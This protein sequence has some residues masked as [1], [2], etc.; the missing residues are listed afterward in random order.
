MKN[1]LKSSFLVIGII[2]LSACATTKDTPQGKYFKGIVNHYFGEYNPDEKIWVDKPLNKYA[3]AKIKKSKLSLEDFEKIREKMKN[4]K[5]RIISEQ[6]N[7]FEYCLGEEF[8]IGILYPVNPKHYGYDG[9]EILYE[10]IDNWSIGLSY[11]ESGVKHC[12]KDQIP[13]IELE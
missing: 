13:V 1:L 8:Y 11:N 10:S 6:D 9:E 4:E 3:I 12:L 7:Y 5:W 2:F